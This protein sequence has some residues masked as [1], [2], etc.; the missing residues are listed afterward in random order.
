MTDFRSQNILAIDCSSSEMKLGLQFGE[1]RLVKSSTGAEQAHGA[2]ILKGITGLLQSAN[3]PV[4]N[5]NAIIV[6]TG[7]GSFTGLRIALACAKGMAVAL[8]IP[9]VSVNLFE[10]AAYKLSTI[11]RQIKVLVPFKK[12]SF[13]VGTVNNGIFD[14]SSIEAV[15]AQEVNQQ[16]KGCLIAGINTVALASIITDKSKIID[17]D[18]TTYDAT[19]LIFLGMEKLNRN[20]IPD[21]AKLEPLYVQ[22]SLAEIKF[23][24]RF[25]QQS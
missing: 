16:I 15:S 13:F 1:D 9:V 24:E 8:K 25:K 17:A 12:D 21:L 6:T 23:E 7:P 18:K 4:S 20:E 22:K 11:N 3:C 2:L 14:E 5:L 19:E 10:L